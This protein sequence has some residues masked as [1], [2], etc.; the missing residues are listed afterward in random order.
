MGDQKIYVVAK[1]FNQQGCLAYKCKSVNEA[2]CLPGTLEAIRQEGIQIVILND[3][4]IYAEY[5]PYTYMEN[6]AKFIEVVS[7]LK[8]A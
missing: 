1:V 3:P 6:M 4:D 7:N 8:S 2:R 5:A